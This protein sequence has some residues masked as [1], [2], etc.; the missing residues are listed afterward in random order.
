M[1]EHLGGADRI[2]S[3]HEL[4]LG[5]E[6]LMESDIAIAVGELAAPHLAALKEQHRQVIAVQILPPNMNQEAVDM[7]VIPSHEPHEDGPNI[8]TT[9]GLINKINRLV[10]NEAMSA[11]RDADPLGLLSLPSPRYALLIGGRHAGGNI[12]AEDAKAL[13]TQLNQLVNKQGGS[14]MVSTCKRTEA[15]TAQ[16]AKDA[17]A[18][19]HAFYD[20]KQD[21][22]I[23]N[24]YA[25]ML[26]LAD[27]VIV[28]GDSARMCSEACSTGAPVWITMPECEFNPYAGLHNHLVEYAAA[29]FFADDLKDFT[30]TP[31]DEAKRIAELIQARR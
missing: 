26:A 31:L 20:Y 16:A 4:T 27:G 23:Q 9:T 28:T 21:R 7:V 30:P 8:V 15:E 13:V 2:F 5:N 1:A 10:L 29:Q 12:T 25:A 6:Q 19:P 24:P 3:A 18:I 14:L 11:L 22:H 17:L